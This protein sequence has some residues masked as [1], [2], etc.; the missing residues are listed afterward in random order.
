MWLP[1]SYMELMPNLKHVVNTIEKTERCIKVTNGTLQLG[2]GSVVDPYY[3]I[4]CLNDLARS[5]SVVVQG[6]K[7]DDFLAQEQQKKS[8]YLLQEQWQLCQRQLNRRISSMRGLSWVTQERPEPDRQDQFSVF[9]V[10]FDGRDKEGSLLHYQAQCRVNEA[11]DYKMSIDIHP[12][13]LRP[14]S[15]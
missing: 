13:V 5:Y 7:V 2:R 14:A 1:R 12:D 4:T 6:K 8:H 3:R 15:E 10:D 9:V 11:L